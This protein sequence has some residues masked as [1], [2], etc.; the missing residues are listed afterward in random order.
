VALGECGEQCLLVRKVLIQ[1]ADAHP[2]F[3]RNAVRG[4]AK[5]LAT[6]N[7]SCGFENV[8]D[9]L[10]RTSLSRNPARG[11]RPSHSHF[12]TRVTCRIQRGYCDIMLDRTRIERFQVLD[13]HH[14]SVPALVIA[15]A[16]LGRDVPVCLFLYGG[17]GNAE[18]LLSLEPLLRQAW[19]EQSLPP[20]LVGCLGV[21]PFC[22]YLDAPAHGMFWQQAVGHGLLRAVREHFAGEASSSRAGLVGVSMGGYGALKIAFS[23]PDRFSSVA[24]VAPMLEPS[25]CA[26]AVPL[27]NRCH[28]PE[29]V[30][31][32]LLGPARDAR[33]FTADH[34]ISRARRHAIQIRATDLAIRI[35]A[36][37]RDALHAHDGAEALHRALWQLDIRHEYQLLRDADHVGPTLAPRLLEAFRWVGRYTPFPPQVCPSAEERALC[38]YVAPLYAAASASDPSVSRNYG[39]F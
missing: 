4:R 9:S 35:D 12:R 8:V 24:V 18:T 3:D 17:G 20:L 37:S 13:V 1:T 38:D 6:K 5:S 2:S 14:G 22:F 32:M 16:E 15:P 26:E 34:P 21:P 7:P 10:Q 39:R 29:T 31:P 27:R 28:Y 19:Q 30:P 23:E 36:G 33:L 11:G 25:E